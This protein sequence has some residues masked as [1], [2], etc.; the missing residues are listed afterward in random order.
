[1]IKHDY[2]KANRIQPASESWQDGWEYTL[3]ERLVDLL[4]AGTASFF[5]IAG[6]L[7]AVTQIAIRGLS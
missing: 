2:K 4:I 5:V 1:M 3:G 6:V 7:F